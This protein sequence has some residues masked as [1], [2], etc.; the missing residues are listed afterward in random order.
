MKS[1]CLYSLFVVKVHILI[2][3][4]IYV[5]VVLHRYYC[6]I[7]IFNDITLNRPIRMY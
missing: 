4:G 1:N 2:T 3:G 6:G 7:L 5:I